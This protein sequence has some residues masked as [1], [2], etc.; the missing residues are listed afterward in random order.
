MT[1]L[2]TSGVGPGVI[3]NVYFDV[4]ARYSWIETWSARR[5][6]ADLRKTLARDL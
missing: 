5:C 4:L 6:G 1:A 2:S 3:E